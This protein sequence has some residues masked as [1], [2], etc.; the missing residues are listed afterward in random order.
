EFDNVIARN[1]LAMK[2]RVKQGVDH[3]QVN[4]EVTPAAIC[5]EKLS[6]PDTAGYAI[7]PFK[8]AYYF[9]EMNDFSIPLGGRDIKVLFTPGHSPDAVS[10]YD[11]DNGYLWTGDTFYEAPIWLFD[12]GTNLEAYRSSIQQLAGL[13]G[14]LQ[15]VFPAHNIPVAAPERLNEL[16]TAFEQVVTGEKEVAKNNDNPEVS[17][18]TFENF[19]FIIRSQLLKSYQ[20]QP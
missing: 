17:E 4:G 12:K 1:T 8:V 7:K 13:S 6:N 19:S 9:N 3:D 15:K 18:F 14:S 11:E 2:E 16:V 5:L 10:L 20:T